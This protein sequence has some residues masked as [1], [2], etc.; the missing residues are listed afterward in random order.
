[1]HTVYSPKEGTYK[2]ID[3][4]LPGKASIVTYNQDEIP[5]NKHNKWK[6]EE[7][8]AHYYTRKVFDYFWGE[9]GRKSYDNKWGN[10]ELCVNARSGFLVNTELQPLPDAIWDLKRRQVRIPGPRFCALEVIAHEWTHAVIQSSLEN[11]GLKV[12]KLI[13]RLGKK[14]T[15]YYDFLSVMESVSNLFAG[16]I[17]PRGRMLSREKTDHLKKYKRVK[18]SGG[19][20]WK[21]VHANAGIPDKA[22][23]LIKKRMGGERMGKIYYL[24]VDKLFHQMVDPETRPGD[25]FNSFFKL[26]DLLLK[27]LKRLRDKNPPAWRKEYEK[28][29]AIIQ[30]SFAA[31]GVGKAT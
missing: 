27:S 2:L 15:H 31:V 17:D 21:A 24:T 12:A 26:R 8:D 5:E 22:A 23:H 6:T 30:N 29:K 19:D 11:K 13:L 1:M 3:H 16:L 20:F 25:E 10:M 7:V 9:H 28:D 18:G 14:G 4:S